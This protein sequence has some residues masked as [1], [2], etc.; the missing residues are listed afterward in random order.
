[1]R[2]DALIVGAGYY[3]CTCANIL[4][5]RG[6]AVL[7][8]D[9][10]AHIAGNSCSL[11]GLNGIQIHCFGPHIFHTSNERVWEYVNRFADFNHFQ[12]VPVAVW[13]DEIYNLPFNMNTFSRLWPDVR[14]P[15]QAA[16]RIEAQRREA[17][18]T[19]E[20]RNLEEQALSMAGRDIYEKLIK[21]YT[22]KQWGRPCRE[23]P[24][25]IIKRLPFRFTYDNNYFN[26]PHQ[27]VPT[28]GYTE[29]AVRML[30]DDAFTGS[31]ATRLNTSY[32]G[33]VLRG[34]DGLPKRAEAD[35]PSGARQGDFLLAGGDCAARIIYTGR[36]DGFFGER[37]GTLEY[38]SLRFETDELPETDNY[39]GS[40]I[41]NYT[42]ADVPYTRII[43]HKHFAFGRRDGGAGGSAYDPA[44]AIP[45]TVITREYPKTWKPGDEPY[46]PVNDAAN[47]ARYEK[48]RELGA[49]LSGITFG[50]RLGRYVYY[51]MDQ[52]IAQALEDMDEQ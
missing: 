45:G 50:G 26:D 43:E 30:E 44:Q 11:P 7:V 25:F 12:N 22:E 1:M 8:I 15:A 2:Y 4:A 46:Y 21:E 28:K 47:N 37:E 13:H 3:G 16:E 42:T 38:R 17:G 34:E 51:N 18:I 23:L 41:V 24:A 48:Y 29:L 32:E 10:R 35:A 33:L 5:S 27:G 40:A 31:I 52:V 20:P 39:Q 49:G 19:G 36:I 9:E 14:T 6:A